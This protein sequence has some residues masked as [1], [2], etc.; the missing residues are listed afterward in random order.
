M[1][2]IAA[3]S[4]PVLDFRMAWRSESP[5]VLNPYSGRELDLTAG[6]AGRWHGTIA[7]ATGGPDRAVNEL[8]L[9]A[10]AGA[11]QGRR[12]SVT[13]TLPGPVGWPFQSAL[14]AAATAA[15]SAVASVTGGVDLTLAIIGSGGTV[16]VPG[17]CIRYE[18][19]TYMSTAV[20]GAVVTVVPE[21]VPASG[22]AAVVAGVTIPV[23][24]DGS[25]TISPRRRGAQEAHIFQWT[26]VL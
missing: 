9:Q 1:A 8:A 13:L 12:N 14:P 23:R 20:N 11:L 2:G 4:L 22:S 19:R 17:N 5:L 24:I 3:P 21:I 6:N 18:G 26:E 16:L 7:W 10:F 15:V 25:A